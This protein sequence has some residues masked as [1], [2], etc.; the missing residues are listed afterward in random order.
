MSENITDWQVRFDVWT[1]Y[2]NW[3]MPVASSG[4]KKKGDINKDTSSYRANAKQSKEGED[5]VLK[6]KQI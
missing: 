1:D 4:W 6:K 5:V 3:L 2:K